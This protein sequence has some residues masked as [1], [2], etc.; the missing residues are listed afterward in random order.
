MISLMPVWST[1]AQGDP[2]SVGH[3]MSH[4]DH[5]RPGPPICSCSTNGL[6]FRK[7]LTWEQV[8]LTHRCVACVEPRV[9]SAPLARPGDAVIGL[10]ESYAAEPTRGSTAVY[11]R[12]LRRE[13][14]RPAELLNVI[15]R[16][17]VGTPRGAVIRQRVGVTDV[18]IGA[19]TVS[20]SKL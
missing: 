18:V 2:A 5:G 14:R 16:V 19:M 4:D 1:L 6:Y 3:R 11:V 8:P 7:D 17:V 10:A 20:L 15:L 9:G 12:R 13:T